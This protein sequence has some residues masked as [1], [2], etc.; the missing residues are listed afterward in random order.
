[1]SRAASV[2]NQH[3]NNKELI[4]ITIILIIMHK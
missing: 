4:Y 3:T 2:V 1:M